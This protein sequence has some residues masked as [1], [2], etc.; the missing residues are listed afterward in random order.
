MPPNRAS[1]RRNRRL[2]LLRTVTA[3]PSVLRCCI[4]VVLLPILHGLPHLVCRLGL[5]GSSICECEMLS[6]YNSCGSSSND[7]F[8]VF[9]SESTLHTFY[10]RDLSVATASSFIIVVTV[11]FIVLIIIFAGTCSYYRRRYAL[12]A[13]L[14]DVVTTARRQMVRP[15]LWEV[16]VSESRG[17]TS[18]SAKD[19]GNSIVRFSPF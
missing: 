15:R 11:A 2:R 6:T 9:D 14:D 19:W 7:G 12:E 13:A 10:P 16:T 3:I 1:R 5:G 8:L 4:V 17:Q 18:A